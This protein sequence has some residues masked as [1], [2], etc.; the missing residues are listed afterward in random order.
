M[1]KIV[2]VQIKSNQLL[3]MILFDTW[4]VQLFI[5]N[6]SKNELEIIYVR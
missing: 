1:Q 4:T 5:I 2:V 3:K 6:E